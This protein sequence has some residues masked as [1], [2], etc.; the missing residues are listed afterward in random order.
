MT[1]TKQTNEKEKTF[2]EKVKEK[3]EWLVERINNLT[4]EANTRTEI[5]RLKRD[6]KSKYTALGKKVFEISQASSRKSVFQNSEVKEL[7]S[8]ILNLSKVIKDKEKETERYRERETA[9]KKTQSSS[10]S[11]PVAHGTS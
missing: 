10:V 6:L 3:V 4:L 7:I 1:T 5:F 9:K 8:V 2:Q 11:N